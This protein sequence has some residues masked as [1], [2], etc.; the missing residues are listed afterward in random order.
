V[1]FQTRV[2]DSTDFANL[3]PET[4]YHL[5]N[6]C[7]KIQQQFQLYSKRMPQ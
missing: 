7:M 6:T 1:N 4:V 2:Q 3:A 5:R